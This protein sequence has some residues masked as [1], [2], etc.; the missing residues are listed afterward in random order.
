[1]S[2]DTGDVIAALS[3]LIASVSAWAALSAS[4]KTQELSEQANQYAETSVKLSARSWSDQYY[5]GLTDWANQVTNHISMAIHL[6]DLKC[7]GQSDE[8]FI[9]AQ[10]FE[11]KTALSALLDRGRWYLPNIIPEKYGQH[12]ERAYR[13]KRKPAMNRVCYA[14]NAIKSYESLKKQQTR[15][16]LVRHQRRFVSEI[17]TLLNPRK[18]VNEINSVLD[19]FTTVE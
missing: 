11:T 1:M 2:L 3:A 17:Q 5:Q 14:Y 6:V 4:K 8:A 7:E 12:K 15:E 19:T 18:R 16:E 9:K 10:W 13:G